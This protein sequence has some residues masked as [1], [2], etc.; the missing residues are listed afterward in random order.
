MATITGTS[1]N[2]TFIADDTATTYNGGGGTDDVV[3]YSGSTSA[4]NLTFSLTA[5]DPTTGSGT[6]GLAQGDG[7]YDIDRVIGTSFNDVYT[8]N[9]VNKSANSLVITEA[10]NGGTDTVNTNYYFYNLGANIENLTYTGTAAFTGNGNSLNNVITGNSGNDHLAGGAGADTLVGGAGFDWATYQSSSTALTIDL[11]DGSRSTGDAAGDV[12]SGIESYIGS[13]SSDTFIAGNTATTFDGGGGSDD[14]VDYSGSTSAINLSFSLTLSSPMTG[15]G[16]G[17]LAQG[18]GFYDIDRVIGTSFND[19]YTVNAV[20]TSANG[21]VI[22]EAANGGTDTVNTN[23]YYYNLGANIENLT[24]TG[25]AAFTGNGNGLN[26]VITGNSGKDTLSGNDGDDTL[27]GGAG[28]D[29]LIGGLGT[30]T[31]SYAT[32]GSGITLNLKTGVHTGDATGDTFS[33]IERFAGSSYNDTFISS[34]AA[35]GFDGGG[36]TDTVDYSTST[37]AVTVDLTAGTGSGG[38]AA[39]DTLTSIEKVIGSAYADT[40]S[41]S[42][43]GHILA[44]GDGDD[45]LT[46]ASSGEVYGGEGDDQYHL[47]ALYNATAIVQDDG[48]TSADVVYLPFFSIDSFNETQVGNDLVLTDGTTT[49]NLKDWF[50]GYNSIE[51]FITTDGHSFAI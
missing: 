35:E 20:N 22:T 7:F 41:S 9:A 46:L 11:N 19:V 4:I 47:E 26:N 30:D 23:Y 29:Q 18:D 36:G 12:Y 44:G 16:T 15:S 34:S 25:T 50:A 49:L 38:D 17:G 1:G 40:L 39:G 27:I 14:V 21:L 31:A 28:A 5:V 43:A 2:D 24:Y 45:V 37:A 8:V 13:T 42:T 32:A 48:S 6:G 10:A 3:D 33:S 51:T